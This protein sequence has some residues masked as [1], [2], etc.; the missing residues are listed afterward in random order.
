MNILAHK[1]VDNNT[2]SS[3]A[4][5]VK[6]LLKIL[7]TESENFIEWFSDNKMIVNTDKLKSIIIQKS[8]QTIKPKQFLL[9][10]NVIEIASSVEL[11][12]IQIDVQLNFNLHISITCKSASKQLNALVRLKCFLGF[13]ERKV[14][15]NSFILSNFNYCSLV[16]SIS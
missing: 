15:I 13:E 6:M 16:W 12:G 2:P 5:S 8:N 14:L 7:I 11:L 1:L 10:N 9:G 3:F 4:K